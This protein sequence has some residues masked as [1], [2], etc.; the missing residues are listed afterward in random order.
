MR[1]PGK[2]YDFVEYTQAKNWIGGAF[3]AAKGGAS[4]PVVNPR[5]DKQM[6]SVTLSEKGDVDAAVQAA[7]AGFAKWRNVP[8]KERSQ[9]L[10]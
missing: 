7:K 10:S 8:V 1:F 9:V 2:S 3:V 6:G 4:L 5:H